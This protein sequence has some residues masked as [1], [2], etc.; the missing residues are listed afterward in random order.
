MTPI[1]EPRTTNHEPPPDLAIVYQRVSTDQQDNSLA[2]QSQKNSG[3]L[4]LKSLQ[5]NPDLQFSDPDVSGRI[6]IWDR[7]AGRQAI[8]IL[9]HGYRPAGHPLGLNAIPIRHIVF[10]KLDRIG[11]NAKNMLEFLEWLQKNGKILHIVDFLGEPVTSQGIVGKVM[12]G[13]C[14]LFAEME[15]EL[16]RERINN[17]FAIKTSRGEA[18]SGTEPYGFAFEIRRAPDGSAVKH[19]IPVPAEQHWIR[20]MQAWRHSGLGYERIADELN[21]QGV[22]TKRPAGT[23]IKVKGGREVATC[24]QWKYITVRTVLESKRNQP[25]NHETQSAAA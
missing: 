24:G 7:P 6:P 9:K 20:Q 1:K 19:L 8:E 16:I 3:Y 18:I 21:Q 11:R 13:M 2:V 23:M 17:T 10:P 4:L 12:F 15:V 14:A 5:T 22:P 25:S